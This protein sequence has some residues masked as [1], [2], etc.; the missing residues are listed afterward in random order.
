MNNSRTQ[1]ILIIVLLI[2]FGALLFTSERPSL[3]GIP[4]SS[5]GITATS[6]TSSD[7]SDTV[8]D[9]ATLSPTD[10]T[11]E[12]INKTTQAVLPKKSGA[13]STVSTQP[14]KP[15]QSIPSA[16]T[17]QSFESINTSARAAIVN[18]ICTTR[19]GGQFSPVSGSGVIISADG[20]IVTN[21]HV[22]EY[23]LLKDFNGN[24]DFIDCTIRTGSPAYP[25]YRASL[26]YISP[27]WIQDNADVIVSAN[28]TGTGEHDYAF[29]QI[30][31]RIDGQPLGNIPYLEPSTLDNTSKGDNVL[32]ASYPAGFLSGI[33]IVKD[34]YQTTA[35]GK[36]AD[37]FTFDEDT[38]D[39]ISVPGTVVSQHGSSGGATVNAQGKLIGVIST[40]SSG[41]TTGSRDLRSI[42]MAYINRDLRVEK[43]SDLASLIQN[44]TSVRE[45]FD[46]NFAPR[47][48]E[49][50][51]DAILGSR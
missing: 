7:T 27:E 13:S 14:E 24:K 47:L 4:L 30:T 44:A 22:A 21:A 8:L 48:Q 16:A 43:N 32:L 36:V 41:D 46:K 51:T 1:N 40:S 26:V 23:F 49:I 31:S 45:D 6:S 29:L 35:I 10:S 15:N 39:V 20:V 12:T 11:P 17:T 25:T 3:Y 5:D 2:V 38:I 34:L 42:T 19:Y 37:V 28:P 33:A 9:Q 18:I 50:L